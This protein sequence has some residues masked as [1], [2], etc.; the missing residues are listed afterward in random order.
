MLAVV[1]ALAMA[2]LFGVINVIANPEA[3][4]PRWATLVFASSRDDFAARAAVVV[5]TLLLLRG[6]LGFV[7][8]RLQANL[9]AETDRAVGE[10]IF[11]RAL[12][13][14]YATHL[15]RNSAEIV[16]VLNWSTADVAAN[17]VGAT[18]AVSVDLLILVGLAV[19]LILLQPLIAL[20]MIVYFVAVAAVLV[21]ALSPAICR[22]ADEEHRMSTLTNRSIMEGL[23]GVKAF[24][25]AVATEVVADEH[26]RHRSHLAAIRQRK[27]F[28]SSMSRQTLELSV[29]LGLGVLTGALFAFQ[30]S[31]KALASLGLVI[32]V[33]FRALPSLSRLLTTLGAMRSASVSLGKIQE[34]LAQ[35]T[36]HDDQAYLPALEFSR[37]ISFSDVSF[38]YGSASAPALNQLSVSVPFGSS[39]GIVGT[40]G[41][42]K[43]TM[44]DL[45]LGLLEP[46]SGQIEV[47]GVQLDRS[48][49]LAWRHLIGYVPQ[50]VFMLDGS[51]RDNV[52]FTGRDV[53]AD[54]GAVWAALAQAQLTEFVEGLPEGL[55][56]IIGERGARLSGGQR[57]RVGIARALY[58]QPSLLVLDEA[59]S[60][61][62]LATEAAM[63]KTLESI[64][65][66]ITKVIIA[67]RLPTVRGCD[68]ILFLKHGRIA[69]V[70]T[71]A[72]LTATVPEFDILARLGAT[73]GA[74]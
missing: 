41:A 57:Q 8:A 40:S 27:V 35:P 32:A 23:Q 37:Q 5:F 10:R 59:T 63:A 51:I 20:G 45:L 7:A 38:V 56:T 69:G 3:P 31:G 13:Y 62:D 17:L 50:D 42:G 4:E 33:A 22:A 18:A 46:T 64:G 34:E 11:G 72:E 36:T 48:N 71:F 39:L 14:P 9:Q 67:H 19:T 68:R 6:V 43:T 73:T 47:D 24:Q 15:R 61:L 52:V 44:V 49:M 66:S 65:R 21:L 16:A 60:S 12:R 2:G 28:L 54:D 55:D 53:P 58:R 1:E 26:A 74:T 70:G 29:T 25:V 30:S